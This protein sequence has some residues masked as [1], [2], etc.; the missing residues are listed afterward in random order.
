MVLKVNWDNWIMSSK[1]KKIGDTI[2]YRSSINYI[3]LDG[4]GKSMYSNK[5]NCKQC[6]GVIVE[7]KSTGVYVRNSRGIKEFITSGRILW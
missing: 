5:S 1:G 4:C 3:G 2:T 7:K 6:T